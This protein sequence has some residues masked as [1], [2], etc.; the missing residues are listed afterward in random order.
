MCKYDYKHTSLLKPRQHT[1]TKDV[2]SRCSEKNPQQTIRTAQTK[3]F[4]FKHTS[5]SHT[6]MIS[7]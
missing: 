7:I 4:S 6:N 2:N 3:D 5:T 1:A